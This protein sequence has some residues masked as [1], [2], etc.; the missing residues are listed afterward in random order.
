MSSSSAN[1]SPTKEGKCARDAAPG[2]STKRKAA[3]GYIHD[4]P[5]ASTA[6]L[7]RHTP[8]LQLAYRIYGLGLGHRDDLV[9]T[10]TA[11]HADRATQADLMRTLGIAPGDWTQWNTTANQAFHDYAAEIE[12]MAAVDAEEQA[13]A[14]A[15]ETAER[16]FGVGVASV[17]ELLKRSG[18]MAG[19][20]EEIA[21]LMRE[22]GCADDLA[23]FDKLAERTFEAYKAEI[24]RRIHEKEAQKA[25]STAYKAREEEDR[26]VWAAQ[27]RRRKEKEERKAKAAEERRMEREKAKLAKAEERRVAAERRYQ[28]KV[29]ARRKAKAVKARAAS[30]D[31]HQTSHPFEV[32]DGLGDT[33]NTAS[34]A[35]TASSVEPGRGSGP[36]TAISSTDE[37]PSNPDLDLAYRMWGPNLS[38]V[39]ELIER[40][41]ALAQDKEARDR[42]RE[43]IGITDM[44][45]EAWGVMTKKCFEAYKEDIERKMTAEKAKNKQ[46]SQDIITGAANG[47]HSMHNSVDS[48]EKSPPPL[49]TRPDIEIAYRLFGPGISTVEELRDRVRALIQNKDEAAVLRAELKI[50]NKEEC[51]ALITRCRDAYRM[52]ILSRAQKEMEKEK[53]S[54]GLIR[55][56]S[57]SSAASI[58]VGRGHSGGS[59][60]PSPNTS[61]IEIG[62]RDGSNGQLDTMDPFALDDQPEVGI[63]SNSSP[64]LEPSDEGPERDNND[65]DDDD[66]DEDDNLIPDS[67]WLSLPEAHAT[68]ARMATRAADMRSLHDRLS[69]FYTMCV[70]RGGRSSPVPEIERVLDT[71]KTQI[72]KGAIW[73]VSALQD[74]MTNVEP[75]DSGTEWAW[76]RTLRG[77]EEICEIMD[78]IREFDARLLAMEGLWKAAEMKTDEWGKM[79][80]AARK[81]GKARDKFVREWIVLLERFTEVAA[82]EAQS[83]VNLMDLYGDEDEDSDIEASEGEGS[84]VGSDEAHHGQ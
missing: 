75:A 40:V 6:S 5:A 50:P 8:A 36:T 42:A 57:V 62:R 37:I 55:S 19:D 60:S 84:H 59:N 38:S 69:A 47:V 7:P 23:A 13:R 58:E 29:E 28:E 20:D 73:Y 10:A 52:E 44:N 17:D 27:E 81:K 15:L 64:P 79:S 48:V 61:S 54:K 43:V 45:R 33:C 9:A 76:R 11:L 53:D 39:T 80:S 67:H 4:R 32:D 34:P 49:R 31:N 56:D 74:V 18:E 46:T 41:R 21:R 1:S 77:N 65:D 82:K 35:S 26:K 83:W 22:L 14:E 3:A 51:V 63:N 16:I 70:T 25:K 78:R 30:N 12:R 2:T 68:L 66:E 71:C 24:E 72:T